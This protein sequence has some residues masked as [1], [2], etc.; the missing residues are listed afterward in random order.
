MPG[1]RPREQESVHDR[2]L[3]APE[4]TE[5]PL[6]TRSERTSNGPTLAPAEPR[7]FR[8]ADSVR[9]HEPVS[10][11]TGEPITTP[12]G[13]QPDSRKKTQDRADF[14]RVMANHKKLGGRARDPG[15]S[16]AI[17]PDGPEED[18]V[19]VGFEDSARPIPAPE[20][21]FF[22][23]KETIGLPTSA[24]V[25]FELAQL[26]TTEFE[27][28][29]VTG[30]QQIESAVHETTSTESQ[31]AK[32]LPSIEQLKTA[33]D[34]REKAANKSALIA[35]QLASSFAPKKL[36]W[37]EGI[38]NAFA[39]AKDFLATPITETKKYLADVGL[40][41]NQ[42]KELETYL[43]E[44]GQ[45]NEPLLVEEM[46][47]QIET[48]APS[49]DMPEA[50]YLKTI[51]TVRSTWMR[52]EAFG[53]DIKATFRNGIGITTTAM[54][55]F[56]DKLSGAESI[57][58]AS[59]ELKRAQESRAMAQDR[60][61]QYV[62]EQTSIQKRVATTQEAYDGSI[63]DAFETF[64]SAKRSVSI[65]LLKEWLMDAESTKKQFSQG[66]R[67]TT[68]LTSAIRVQTGKAEF[69]RKEMG[70]D[71]TKSQ[72]DLISQFD[73]ILDQLEDFADIINTTQTHL[74]RKD[75]VA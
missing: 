27:Y 1:E 6:G 73:D 55:G 72:R 5:A 67:S 36:T 62:T 37:R 61:K 42:E 60:L 13:T 68:E 75:K 44:T 24:E 17:G 69:A 19:A 47:S 9:V 50:D 48:I 35:K 14:A 38:A 70:R 21:K 2:P 51:G 16:F 64:E 26:T 39:G 52:A 53:R 10:N 11:R 65:Q 63:E 45:A 49:G 29:T 15:E 8:P 22:P 54:K 41:R 32:N 20:R 25:A 57:T 56:H 23:K 34:A 31:L 30:L 4:R 3:P 59:R 66:S 40:S 43:A 74:E 18:V 28:A 71:A 46:L 12:H 58:R 7:S 33:S